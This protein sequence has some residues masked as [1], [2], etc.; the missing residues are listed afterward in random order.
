MH[1]GDHHITHRKGQ[2]IG[3]MI[4]R[5]LAFRPHRHGQPPGNH[6]VTFQI[7]QRREGLLSAKA[8]HHQA[9]T[10]HGLDVGDRQ[11]V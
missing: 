8:R 3:R 10:R 7:D 9:G 5:D 4:D 11:A 2:N 1:H 6:A